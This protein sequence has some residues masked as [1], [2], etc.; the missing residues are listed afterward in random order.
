MVRSSYIVQVTTLH[1]RCFLQHPFWTCRFLFSTCLK[2]G[3]VVP[4]EKQQ[5]GF[6]TMQRRV[7]LLFATALALFVIFCVNL[8]TNPDIR[9]AVSS[10][11]LTTSAEKSV[12][13]PAFGLDE[14]E[15]N[16]Q[17]PTQETL[18]PS[19]AFSFDASSSGAGSLDASSS[20]FKPSQGFPEQTSPDQ[21]F[22]ENVDSI[23]AGDSLPLGT[24]SHIFLKYTSS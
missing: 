11:S 13:P 17:S 23:S 22:P 20:E 24:E 1:P 8:L 19:D 21:S 5:H 7:L 2:S 4:Y 9:N 15:S 12:A 18:P 16:S 3:H 6:V 14:Q 10:W